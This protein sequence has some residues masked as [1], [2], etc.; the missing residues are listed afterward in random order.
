MKKLLIL[1]IL[2]VAVMMASCSENKGN[3]YKTDSICSFDYSN[4]DEMTGESKVYFKSSFVGS[5][6]VGFLNKSNDDQT[7]FLG[8]CALVGLADDVLEE[9]HVAKDLCVYGKGYNNTDYY[10]TVKYNPGSMPE[11]L[12]VFAQQGYGT[13]TLNKVFVNNTNRMVTIAH[14]GLPATDESEAIPA[15]KDG[16]YVKVQLVSDKNNTVEFTLAECKNGNLSVIEEW[17]E[18]DLT[19]LGYVNSVDVVMESNRKDLPMS[20]CFDNLNISAVVNM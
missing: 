6:I 19:K 16:D 5:G 7:V 13:L 11:H 20:F 2:A 8:G 9:G 18:L 14:Y 10:V 4:A 15:F 3:T 12:I 1:P 17:K